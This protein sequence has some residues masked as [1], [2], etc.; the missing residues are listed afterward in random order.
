MLS[1]FLYL[2]QLLLSKVWSFTF[3]VKY[4]AGLAVCLP[5]NPSMQMYMQAICGCY[6][7]AVLGFL[8]LVQ[9]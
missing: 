3:I 1:A 5:V 8:I 9:H 4:F 7:M 2:N 6:V